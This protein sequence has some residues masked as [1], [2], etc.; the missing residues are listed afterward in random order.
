M[1]RYALLHTAAEMTD[2]LRIDSAYHVPGDG[3]ETG[4]VASLL[5]DTPEPLPVAWRI[6]NN[7]VQH[8]AVNAYTGLDLPLSFSSPSSSSSS[9]SPPP[10]PPRMGPVEQ[11]KR[12]GR[13]GRLTMNQTTGL[14]HH[15]EEATHGVDDDLERC[16]IEIV[17]VE[18]PFKTRNMRTYAPC[19]RKD[20]PVVQ[21]RVPDGVSVSHSPARGGNLVRL[22]VSRT[23]V[24]Q[25]EE[26]EEGL[27][28]PA[29][30][31]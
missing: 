8:V 19:V 9:H 4:S 2:V 18:N 6:S 5:S 11:R 12:R 15:A 20:K 24:P 27:F 13:R 3:D 28:M 30:A 16:D 7:R 23:F 14:A 22:S 21:V 10:P 31:V 17:R 26:E 1:Q 29:A 25:N